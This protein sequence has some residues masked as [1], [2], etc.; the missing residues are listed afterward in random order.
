MLPLLSTEPARVSAGD[1]LLLNASVVLGAAVDV[2]V[3]Y[4]LQGKLV[5]KGE[6]GHAEALAQVPDATCA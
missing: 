2:P 3:E 6:G 4:A 5:A 1:V